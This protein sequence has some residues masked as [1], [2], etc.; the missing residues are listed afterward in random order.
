[1]S[2]AKTI[3][4]GLSGNVSLL[5]TMTSVRS[6]QGSHR[7]HNSKSKRNKLHG[8]SIENIVQKVDES[9]KIILSTMGW[10]NHLF[11]YLSKCVFQENIRC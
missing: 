6:S 9:D 1:M 3:D 7:E 10:S 8:E 4:H 5:E 2:I 11:M